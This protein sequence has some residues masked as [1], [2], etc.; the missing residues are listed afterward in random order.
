[1]IKAHQVVGFCVSIRATLD[2]IEI[3]QNP[4]SDLY[5]IYIRS[6]FTRNPTEI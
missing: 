3:H 2:L 5:L 1:M 6:K 4:R